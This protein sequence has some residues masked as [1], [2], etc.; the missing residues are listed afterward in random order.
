MTADLINLNRARKAKARAL[1]EKRAHESRVRF[2]RTKAE[3]QAS[4]RAD[5]KAAR[6]V[7]GHR[8]ERRGATEPGSRP[9]PRG[10]GRKP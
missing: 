3:R 8:L 1:K 6:H 10:D 9:G 5:E 4:L 2:E 7:E